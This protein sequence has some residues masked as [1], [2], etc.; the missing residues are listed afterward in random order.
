MK[1]LVLLRGGGDRFVWL[2]VLHAESCGAVLLCSARPCC[3]SSVVG[4]SGVRESPKSPEQQDGVQ[5]VCLGFRTTHLC[6]AHGNLLLIC[7]VASVSGHWQIIL[8]SRCS[9]CM[10]VKSPA[11]LKW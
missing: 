5:S 11:P 1:I 7:G 3:R 9:I 4:V 8:G 10:S 6:S 2:E